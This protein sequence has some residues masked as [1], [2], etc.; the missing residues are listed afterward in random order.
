MLVWLLLWLPNACA[1]ERP[2]VSQQTYRVLQEA[3][4]L[5]DEGRSAQAVQR[6]EA[7][8]EQTVH[9]PYEQAVALQSLANAHIERGD[10][11][12]AIP[13]LQR[14]IEL[15]ALPAEAQQR[16][17]YNLAQLYMATQRFS[18]AIAQLEH[19]FEQ[20]QAPPAEAFLLLG[21]AHLQLKQYRRAIEPLRRAI[22][23]SRQPNEGW[24]QS[25]LGAY[26][27]S[28]QYPEAVKLLHR[29]LH[30]FHD[31]ADYWRQLAGIELLRQRY[32]EALA[33]MELA[34][35]NG[36]LSSERDL[37]NLARLYT[38]RDAPYKAAQLLEQELQEGRIEAG[39]KTWEQ[40][41]NAWQQA[42]ETE[43]TVAALEQAL[44]FEPG[45][46]LTLRLARLYLEVER[47]DDA[48]RTLRRFLGEHSGESEQIDRAW[49]LLGIA[50]HENHAPEAARQAFEQALR[51]TETRDQAEQWL[52]YLQSKN[53]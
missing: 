7:L 41:A 22:A 43:R 39:R 18:S 20:A 49:L 9:A 37:L 17:R 51:F 6:L 52:S 29:M 32:G 23:L 46:P 2:S 48:E 15:A 31:S 21:S 26:Y 44:S 24:Y 40:T 13:P 28:E 34:Y 4:E 42:R 33:V 3:Q 53:S 19:W 12:A 14:S 30:L 1:D 11:A 16:A 38:Q 27:E 47:W 35:L 8:A 36:R 45:P 25:L 5:L 10:Y 50:C